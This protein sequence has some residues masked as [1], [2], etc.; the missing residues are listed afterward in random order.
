VTRVIWATGTRTLDPRAA[1]VFAGTMP[2]EEVPPAGLPPS[3]HCGVPRS[4]KFREGHPVRECGCGCGTL[5]R[6]QA[7]GWYRMSRWELWRY[8]RV[9]AG[10]LGEHADYGQL[11]E[12]RVRWRDWRLR[13][14]P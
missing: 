5:Y 4:R 2:R 12:R 11:R 1:A 13:R 6:W 3:H 10:A 9:L 8:R 14:M 7:R